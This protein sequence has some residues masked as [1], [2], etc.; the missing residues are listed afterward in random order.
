MRVLSEWGLEKREQKVD[1]IAI[2]F[3]RTNQYTDEFRELTKAF[4]LDF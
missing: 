1:E 2:Y 4:Y 3:E